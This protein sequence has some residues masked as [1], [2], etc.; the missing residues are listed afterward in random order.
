M[1]KLPTNPD[2]QKR[3]GDPLTLKARKFNQMSSRR[4]NEDYV[5]DADTTLWTETPQERA[6]RLKKEAS[7]SLQGMDPILNATNAPDKHLELARERKRADGIDGQIIANAES[8]KHSLLDLHR[9]YRESD[10]DKEYRKQRRHERAR[11]R[12]RSPDQSRGA[13]N[14]TDER[15]RTRHHRESSSRQEHG[16]HSK[17]KSRKTKDGSSHS[18]RSREGH[19]SPKDARSTEGTREEGHSSKGK[20]TSDRHVGSWDWDKAM[21]GGSKLLSETDRKKSIQQAGAL[22]DRFGR[23]SSSYL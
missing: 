14:K 6:I 7:G 13:D 1:L 22:S 23:G 10:R 11:D 16:S 8:R 5:K 19:N 17:R 21:A 9:Q 20:D 12:S 4:A 2:L 18:R 15:R 3:V